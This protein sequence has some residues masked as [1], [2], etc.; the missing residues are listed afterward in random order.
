LEAVGISV[1]TVAGPSW[2]DR[3]PAW[4]RYNLPDGLWAY[5]AGCYFG[6]VWIR[7][8]REIVTVASASGLVGTLLVEG[9]QYGG[10]IRGQADWLDVCWAA[11]A[12]A[13]AV[14]VVARTSNNR[15]QR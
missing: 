7:A 1:D 10:L 4:V 6:G 9:L 3:V 12:C 15:E 2:R 13:L 11:A 8:R 14:V 5:A